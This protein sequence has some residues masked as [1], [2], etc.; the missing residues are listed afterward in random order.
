MA[1]FATSAIRTL[2]V[3][4]LGTPGLAAAVCPPDLTLSAYP[5]MADGGSTCVY[6]ADPV[7][8]TRN[9][10][11]S[12]G[13]VNVTGNTTVNGVLTVTDTNGNNTRGILNSGTATFLKD[14]TVNKP[15][16]QSN[17]AG[18]QN[19]ATLTVEGNTVVTTSSPNAVATLDGVRHNAGTSSYKKNLSI[20][21]QGSTRIGFYQAGAGTVTIGGNLVI[22]QQSTVAQRGLA[23]DVGTMTVTGTTTVTMLSA[24]APAVYGNGTLTLDGLATITESGANGIGVQVNSAGNVKLNAASNVVN[25][26]GAT[27]TGVQMIGNAAFSAGSGLTVNASGRSFSYVGALG[28][29]TLDAVT[30]IAAPVVWQAD[31]STNSTYTGTG[32]HYKGSSQLAGGGQLTLNLGSGALWEASAASGFTLLTLQSNAILDASLLSTLPAAGN[33]TNAGGVVSLARTDATPTNT[34]AL[35]GTFTANGGSL[36]INTVLN[37]AATSVSDVLQVGA[38]VAGGTPTTINVLPDAASAPAL[39]TGKGI[40][41]VRVTGGAAASA[42][43]AF[44]LPGGHLDAGGIRYALVRDAADGNWYL[45]ALEVLPNLSIS[46]VSVAEGN[47]GTTNLVFT[48]SLSAPAPAGGV[49]FDIATADGTATQPADYIAQSL[50]GQVIPAGSTSY[51]FS[52]VVNGDTAIEPDETVLVNITNV[53]NAIVTKAQGTGTISNDDGPPLPGN[54]ALPVPLGGAWSLVLAVLVSFAGLFAVRRRSA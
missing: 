48:V 7:S 12:T 1:R 30:A 51:T 5:S 45:Q 50:T 41:V 27:A 40:L 32:G 31:A 4:I 8:A 28:S 11:A 42:A 35:T 33:L 2:L 13:V 25:A 19:N 15:S 23:Q 22:D 43:N 18:I 44:V 6:T 46:D 52:V 39:T 34:L 9:A 53:A 37:N 54:S 16:G 29:V 49:Q 24:N 10:G 21:S 3:G 14:V 36:A 26:T 38:V 47:S 17:G 20:T